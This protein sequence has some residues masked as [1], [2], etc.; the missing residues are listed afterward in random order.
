MK[1][2][3]EEKR[4]ASTAWLERTNP[5]TGMSIT[6]LQNVFDAAR[7]GD[8]Q[9]LH[10][11]FSEIE[12][13][14][15]TLMVCVDRR[16]SAISNF[17]WSVSERAAM[18]GS[19]SAEQKDAA[20]RFLSDILNFT[21]ALEHLDLAFFRGFSHVQPIWEADGTVRRIELLDSWNFVNR[22]GEWFFNPAC[23]GFSPRDMVDCRDARLMSV[24]RTNRRQIDYPALGVH[25]R[26]AVGNRDWGRFLERHALPKPA[27]TMHA[28]AT[29]DDRALYLEAAE[30]VENGQ[31][32]VWP[33]GAALTDFAGG[34]RGVDPFSS[35]VKHQEETLVRL[36]TGGT[37]GSIAESGAGTLAGNAQ[38]DVWRSI[39]RRDSGVLA[40]A[41]MSALVRPY[42]AQAFPGKPATVD[43]AFDFSE[44]PTPKEVFEMQALAKQGGYTIARNELEEATGFTLEKAPEAAPPG[45]FGGMSLNAAPQTPF[46][47]HEEPFKNDSTKPYQQGD[48]K[49]SDASKGVLAAFAKDTSK[50]AD[51]VKALL[52]DPTPEKA[53]ALLADLPNLI[54]DDPALAAVIAEE[55]AKEFC[56]SAPDPSGA[57]AKNS[58]CRAK[59]P[60][61]CQTHGTPEGEKK[62][63]GETHTLEELK[64]IADY[65]AST[66]Q[67]VVNFYEQ[68]QTIDNAEELSRSRCKIGTVSHEYAS[69]IKALTG[70][71]TEGWTIE[72][73][74]NRAKHI[75][76]RHGGSG[77]QDKSLADSNDVG[78][79]NYVIQHF[80]SVDFCL[81]KHGNKVLSGEYQDKN[82]PSPVLETRMR[83]DGT[84]A[85]Q[86]AV[87]DSRWKKIYIV[88]ARIEKSKEP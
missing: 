73:R 4:D 16:A 43:F 46:K 58:E 41:V 27:V 5:L 44:R 51:A 28:G 11:I 67:N 81:D 7:G 40:R 54:P 10:W 59:D 64:R 20:E 1:N 22:D 50:A 37:L 52:A 68:M 21:E 13:V 29:E 72:L 25:V 30:C 49:S 78:R 84:F 66:D 38:A 3:L 76:K 69:R 14:N 82:G 79:I 55:M 80:D 33:N 57:T 8:T 48:A 35:F 2:L 19:L 42:L 70:L 12:S 65:Q 53:K 15:P 45:P 36:A 34:S 26:D 74:G 83:I 61:H 17:S 88:S 24:V 77:K 60:A 47:T 32:S 6:D 87:P 31:V 23:T 75:F 85:V 18:D 86:E 39:V 62:D 63:A 56:S 71:D 9:R